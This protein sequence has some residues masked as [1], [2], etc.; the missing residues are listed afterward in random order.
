[1]T[2]FCF[3]ADAL[4]IALGV[5]GVGSLVQS[6]PRI[7]FLVT[8]SGSA[9]LLFYGALALRRSLRP[10]NL[11]ADDAARST[12]GPVLATAAALTF[13]NPHVYLD[14]VV[15]LGSLSARHAGAARFA[16][17]AG[18]A[19]ASAAWFYGL[20]FGA[21]LAAPLFARPAAWRILDAAIAITMA[22]IAVSLLVQAL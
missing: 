18:A 22:S 17:G 8:L 19:L 10:G 1:M 11:S 6:S 21:R 13:L 15:L 16:F 5:A 14:T 7:L 2:S 4:L 20:G 9:F 3:L 12:L